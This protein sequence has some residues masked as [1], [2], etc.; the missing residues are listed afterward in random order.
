MAFALP[1][2]SADRTTQ[3]VGGTDV[4]DLRY[5]WMASLFFQGEGTAFFPGCGGS[6]ISDRWILSAAHCLID[7][8]TGQQLSPEN[9]LVL[10]G[11][12][13]L[14]SDS[15]V[16]TDVS[17]VVV[18]PNYNSNT[19]QNDLAL[20]ELAESVDFS[21]IT[22]SNSTNPVPENG[23][24]A[25]VAGWGNTAEGGNLSILLQEVDLPIVS[26]NACLPF[27]NNLS[28][29]NNLCAG[30][31]LSGGQD[32]C[33]GD[34][35]GPL[36][37]PRGNQF[38]QAGIVSGG[39]GCAR[40]GIPGIYVRL[41][42]YF[43]WISSFVSVPQVYDGS[44]DA[45]VVAIEEP[46]QTLSANSRVTASVAQ[47]DT[48]IYLTSNTDRVL[49]ETTRG[50]ADLFIFNSITFSDQSLVCSSLS[51]TAID[52]CLLNNTGPHYIAVAGFEESDFVL[53]VSVGN[54]N[55]VDVEIETLQ[56][57]TPVNR[58]VREGTATVY[59]ATSGNIATL[60]SISGDA[61]LAVFSRANFNSDTLICLSEELDSALDRCTYNIN[62]PEVYVVVYGFTNASYTL[63]I[64]SAEP[65]VAPQSDTGTGANSDN[66]AG[67]GGG[68]SLSGI[69]I[70]LSLLLHS[71]YRR[72]KSVPTA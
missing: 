25:T 39:L 46:L 44:N 12:V 7:S 34:S 35:G 15:R 23:E 63:A 22:L 54:G 13:D 27:Y 49:L 68:G 72:N 58:N 71:L 52:E 31:L 5:P 6:L 28:P 2:H 29:V 3:I 21:P 67:G 33:Q 8:Q 20:L 47:A 48:V 65:V 64:R 69:I 53:S 42:S 4:T 70:I 57:D 10:L 14:A 18:H 41:S 62:G 36:F 59:K 24:R 1:L 55:V 50:D 38:V 19:L 61:D 32:S 17:R 26:H 30:R 60:T 43:D 37:V 66:G 11:S 9:V 40:A 56:L 16:F 51:T 45:E